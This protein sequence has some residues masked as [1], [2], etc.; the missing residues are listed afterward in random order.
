M[1]TEEGV[2]PE[3]SGKE[4]TVYS[5]SAYKMEDIKQNHISE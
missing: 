4:E 1:Q 5:E 2:F 3:L